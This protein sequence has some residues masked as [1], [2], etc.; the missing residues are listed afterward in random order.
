MAA[1]QEHKGVL[2]VQQKLQL[3]ATAASLPALRARHLRQVRQ[4]EG[5]VDAEFETM[6]VDASGPEQINT[7][8]HT[9]IRTRTRRT[10][11]HTR[12]DARLV[13]PSL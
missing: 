13:P 6:Q 4:K 10:R 8:S 2:H 7:Y 9:H 3:A 12:T 5:S 11:T 1:R